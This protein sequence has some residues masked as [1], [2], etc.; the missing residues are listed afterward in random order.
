[1]AAH[2]T[3]GMARD[4]LITLIVAGAAGLLAP[5]AHGSRTGALARIVRRAAVVVIALAVIGAATLAILSPQAL[6]EGL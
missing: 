5:V 2:E 1:L 3:G 6:L 4:I